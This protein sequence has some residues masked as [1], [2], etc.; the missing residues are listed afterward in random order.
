MSTSWN[1]YSSPANSP[2][3]GGD[4]EKA[5]GFYRGLSVYSIFEIF[6]EAAAIRDAVTGIRSRPP[7]YFWVCSGSKSPRHHRAGDQSGHKQ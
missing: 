1:W 3:S 7:I 2:T 6:L 4:N 5:P